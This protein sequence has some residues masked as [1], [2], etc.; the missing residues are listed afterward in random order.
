MPLHVVR[1]KDTGSV[2]ISGTVAGQR[3]RRRAQSD[4]LALAREE[5]AALEAQILRTEWHGER[6]GAR[7]FAEAVISYLE[8]AQR[9]YGTKRRLNRILTALGDPPLSA[10]DQNAIDQVR[11]KILSAD[12]S[13]STVR[14]GVIT[15]IRAVLLHAHRR[16]WCDTPSFEIPRESEGRARYLLPDEAERLL[17]ASSPHIRILLTLL[18]GTG[19]R[20]A[21][22][23][24]LLWRDVD[25]LG[26]RAILWPDQTKT[27]RRRNVILPPRVVI[28]LANL[29]HRDG[30]VIRRDDGQPYADR[31]REGGGQIKTA[32]RATLRRANLDPSFSPHDLRHT[33]ASWHYALHRDLLAL[34]VAGGWSSVTLVER[35][36]HLMKEGHQDAIKKFLGLESDSVSSRH[37]LG[38]VGDTASPRNGTND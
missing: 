6:R 37:F 19:M 1:R 4:N 30:P 25:L 21:E 8:A 28:C 23:L 14:R 26:G 32:W 3:I 35:Y 17:A 36:A 12:A 16:G 29:A 18:I 5:A 10:I 24:E 20:M 9:T 15:P 34:K 13:M 11:R 7:S 27:R 38:P 33:W 2:T 22:A 31:R